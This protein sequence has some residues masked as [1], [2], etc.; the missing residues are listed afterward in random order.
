MSKRVLLAG[1]FHETHTFLGDI[2]SLEDFALR[3]GDEILTARDDGSPLSGVLEFAEQN[4]W[5]VLPSIDLRATPAGSV[6]D[7]VLEVFTQAFEET[8]SRELPN[9]IDGIYL[10]LHGAMVCE[11]F[12]DVEGEVLRRIRAIEGLGD[13]PICGVLDLHGN[14]SEATAT[15]AQGFIAYRKNPHIDSRAASI[16]GAK[17]LDRIL[18]TGERP[19]CVWQQPSVMWPPTGTGTDDDPM[20][21]LE[22]MSREI[23]A[24]YPDIFAVN[25]F[26]GFSF[27][28]TPDTGVS[29]NAITFGSPEVAQAEI[30]KL[31]DWT[32]ANRELGNKV[33][34][35]LTEILDNLDDDLANRTPIILV[36]PADN[37]G[38]GAPGDATTI[39]R[40]FVERGIDNCA[41]IIN[42]PESVQ[43][44]SDVQV[45][46]SVTL[47]IGGKTNDMTEGPVE[48]EVTLLSKSDGQFE[49]E[50][51]NSHLASMN[52]IYI[53]MGPSATVQHGGLRI[54]LTSRKTPPFDLGQ[55]RSQGIVPEELSVIGVKAA[56][57]HR[58]AYDKITGVTYTVDT[59]GPCSSNLKTFTF[60]K[61][62]RPIFPLD[63]D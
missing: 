8:A 51:H 25:V 38:G 18:T 49:L 58:R 30:D 57:A 14:I 39:L 63:D 60:E 53:N 52:G 55:F 20:N 2:T 48:L 27:A 12:P 36:E 29:F 6:S 42:D 32:V 54:L 28:D 61:L 16:D 7:E 33:D 43:K 37:I 35:S 47:N 59:A 1:V 44:L 40:E 62:R 56:V 19:A 22:A 45:G 9:G 13:T 3:R 15:L 46:D 41:V 17:L 4:G 23:E 5:E 11:S 24:N 10:V 34:A 31:S 21:A 50:D 26:G